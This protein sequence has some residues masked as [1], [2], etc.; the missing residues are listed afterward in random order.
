MRLLH[1]KKPT[2]PE[3]EA[4]IKW[5]ETTNIEIKQYMNII[6]DTSWRTSDVIN[7]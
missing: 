1:E 4:L 7:Y 2:P 3:I 6:E 5:S